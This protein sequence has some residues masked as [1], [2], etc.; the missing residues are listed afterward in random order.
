MLRRSAALASALA[1]LAGTGGAAEVSGTVTAS[2]AGEAREWVSLEAVGGGEGG[3]AASSNFHEFGEAFT[4]VSLLARGA[5]DGSPMSDVIVI[6]FALAGAGDSLSETV[7]YAIVSYFPDGLFPHYT[8]DAP[9][10]SVTS[11]ALDG[12]ALVLEGRFA[13]TLGRLDSLTAA[14]DPLDQMAIEGDFDVRVLR[15]V[16]E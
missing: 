3:E 9:S 2:L 1:L 4:M 5:P 6:E 14:R 7:G 15:A 12:D 13:A 16:I 10:I 11:T 8:D